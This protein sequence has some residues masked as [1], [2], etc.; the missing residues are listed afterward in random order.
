MAPSATDDTLAQDFVQAGARHALRLVRC[1]A[2][3]PGSWLAA[4]AA[5]SMTVWSSSLGARPSRPG[6]QVAAPRRRHPHDRGDRAVLVDGR[7]TCP[8]HQ[9]A[10]SGDR[11]LVVAH[12]QHL[13]GSETVVQTHAA[14]SPCVRGAVEPAARRG[15]W[16]TGHGGTGRVSSP[17]PRRS[18]AAVSSTALGRRA[19]VAGGIDLDLP[20][21]ERP[22]EGDPLARRRHPRPAAARPRLDPAVLGPRRPAPGRPAPARAGPAR[23]RRQRPAGRPVRRGDRRPRRPHR[24][25][26]ARAVPRGRRRPLLGRLHRAAP[27]GG[28]PRAGARGRRGRRRAGLAARRRAR[29]APRCA[30][31]WSRRAAALPPRALRERLRPGR[32]RRGGRRRSRPRCCR[33]SRR[34]RTAWP[35]P[36]CRSS[37]TWRS[38]TTCST[39]TRRRCCPGSPAR[40]GWSPRRR[41]A[42]TAGAGARRRRSTGPR[43]CSR[44]PA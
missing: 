35:A 36:G 34:A 14:P 26:R 18:G 31:G 19:P 10:S 12:R 44:S 7:S 15:R 37:G 16:R 39:P 3:Q 24:A 28:R 40:P 30:P 41:S 22:P 38:S 33:S 1:R 9:A 11:A 27:G 5:A 23:P 20:G 6:P 32:W 8:P 43:A 29:T 25:R 13:V 4:N 2:R 17:C 42:A 21:V